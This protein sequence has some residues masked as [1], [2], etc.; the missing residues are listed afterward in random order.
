MSE[1]RGGIG[2][3]QPSKNKSPGQA[4][5]CEGACMG[6]GDAGARLDDNVG[7]EAAEPLHGGRA[8]VAPPPVPFEG[9]VNLGAGG[10]LLQLFPQ[11]AGVLDGLA[12]AL[13]Q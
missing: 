6:L 2:R 7:G 4:C 13:A 3:G 9:P 1:A 11:H 5:G 10:E 8:S 12:T